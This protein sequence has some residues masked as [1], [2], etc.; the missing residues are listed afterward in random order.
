MVLPLLV[1]IRFQGLF[2][3]P[4]RSSFHLSLTVLCTIGY[5]GVFSLGRWSSRIP[6]GF[7]VSRGTRG[8]PR[9]DLDF[10]YGAITRYGGTFQSLQ[11]PITNPLI[12]APQP[13]NHRS[14]SGL[15]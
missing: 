15:G 5:R 12:G 7:H 6:T 10:V 4:Y 11:L 1:G 14:R 13:Q 3:S 8:H 9:V 2:H